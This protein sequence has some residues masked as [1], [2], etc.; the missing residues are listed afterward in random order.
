MTRALRMLIGALIWAAMA[1]LAAY[2]YSP[3]TSVIGLACIGAFVGAVLGAHT[4]EGKLRLS[5]L[6]LSAAIAWILSSMTVSYLRTTDLAAT[7]LGPSQ[8][9]IF[10]DGVKWLVQCF[11]LSSILRASSCRRP[12]LVLIEATLMAFLLARLLMGHR[13]GHVNRPFFLVDPLWSQGYDPLPVLMAIGAGLA[14]LSVILANSGGKRKGAFRDTIVA[15]ALIAGLFVVAPVRTLTNLPKPPGAT[16]NDGDAAGDLEQRYADSDKPDFNDRKRGGQNTPVALVLFDDDYTPPGEIYYF[17]QKAYSL[18]NG[19][20]LVVDREGN[21]DRDIP[22]HYPVDKMTTVLDPMPAL[23]LQKVEMTISMLSDLSAPLGL[24]DASE[25]SPAVNPDPTRFRNAYH[26]VSQCATGDPFSTFLSST[27]GSKAWDTAT[28]EHYLKLPD[29]PRYK[30]LAK[31]IEKDIAEEYKGNA[32]VTA[33]LTKMWMDD[34]IIYCLKTKH[35]KADDPVADF[36]F[37]DRTGYCVYIAHAACYLYRAA[38]VPSR[39]VGGYM[40]PSANR[41]TGAALLIGGRYAHAWPEIYIEGAGW[42]PLDVNPKRTLEDPIPPPEE[43]LQALLGDMARKK[44]DPNSADG[45]PKVNLQQLARE[46][47][48]QALIGFPWVVLGLFLLLHALKARHR[49]LAL[50]GPDAR[51]TVLSYKGA[52]QRLAEAGYVRKKGETRGELA[53]RVRDRCQAFPRLTHIHLESTLGAGRLAATPDQLR[54][55]YKE[56]TE[57]LSTGVPAGRRLLRALDP[58]SWWKAR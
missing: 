32:L 19:K 40:V 34:N 9:Y 20:S 4:G 54:A 5:V 50:N 35:A 44:G 37:G 41:G 21:F 1:A 56:V 18:S 36:L 12:Y 31:E 13:E 8:A 17:R 30:D 10:S 11:L 27:P 22:D 28:R 6:Y 49:Y 3:I 47:V 38:G 26:V 43:S 39:V 14:V 57:Q 52:L 24:V 42:M 2:L 48:R 58:I 51:L 7:T 33:Y 46:G 23:E 29:D 15:V 45:K 53:L 55:L 25:F 16:A